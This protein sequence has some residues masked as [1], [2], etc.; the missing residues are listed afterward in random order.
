[1]IAEAQKN[2]QKFVDNENSE[3]NY[4]PLLKEL[5]TN[6]VN[7]IN[8]GGLKGFFVPRVLKK[9]A[10]GETPEIKPTAFVHTANDGQNS[11]WIR[12]YKCTL[13]QNVTDA[14]RCFDYSTL[15]RTFRNKSPEE[16][17]SMSEHN[18]VIKNYE[19]KLNKSNKIE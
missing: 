1:M 19:I 8:V 16:V 11:F 10:V 2:F 7:R 17:I 13:N 5:K 15:N 14:L 9:N 18:K 4:C 12:S 6:V 3:N